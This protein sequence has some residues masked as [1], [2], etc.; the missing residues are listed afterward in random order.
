MGDWARMLVVV[1]AVRGWVHRFPWKDVT[2]EV[3]VVGGDDVWLKPGSPSMKVNFATLYLKRYFLALIKYVAREVFLSV[4]ISDLWILKKS[5]GRKPNLFIESGTLPIFSFFTPTILMIED[6]LGLFG[7]KKN[8]ITKYRKKVFFALCH[9]SKFKGFVFYSFAA[10]KATRAIFGDSFVND[11]SLGVCRP[12]GLINSSSEQI[13]KKPRET[14]DTFC[15]GFVAGNPYGKGVMDV[16]SALSD[17]EKPVELKLLVPEEYWERLEKV[18]LDCN[19]SVEFYKWGITNMYKFLTEIDCLVHPTFM[20]STAMVVVEALSCNRPVIVSDV[21]AT[22]ELVIEGVNGFIVSRHDAHKFYDDRYLP[23]TNETPLS[24]FFRMARDAQK[25]EK[26]DDY[27][28][29]L[30]AA[31]ISVLSMKPAFTPMQGECLLIKKINEII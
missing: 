10:E 3:D 25:S 19:V 6:P 23:I 1:R 16:L 12:P 30:R 17:F 5:K 20:D 7:W 22:A 26:D 4:F 14:M 29:R 18:A 28:T 2:A 13:F 11:F 24:F 8:H 9:H 31:C 15:F 27:V 21:F